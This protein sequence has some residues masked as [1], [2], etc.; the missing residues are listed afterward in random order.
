MRI[1]RATRLPCAV[2]TVVSHART[3]RLLQYVAAPIIAFEPVDPP[4]FPA[5]WSPGQYLV[6]LA[7][8]TIVPFGT[9]VIDISTWSDGESVVIRDN[10]H[11]RLI[12]RWDHLIRITPVGDMTEY[13]DEI[14]VRAGV[15]T[16]FVAAF[17]WFF[18]RHRQR[19][20]LRLVESG[21]S[22]DHA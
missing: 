10:G 18:Y 7:L 22:Y 6:R 1:S 15:L 13:R 8:G 12:R 21:F 16:P 2:D 4:A 14:E 20:W 9:Q 11:S 19:R 5:E 3:P 17:A